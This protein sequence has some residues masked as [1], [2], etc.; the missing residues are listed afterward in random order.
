[1]NDLACVE[2]EE[3][4][5]IELIQSEITD[6]FVLSRLIRANNCPQ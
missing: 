4:V 6:K 3:R 2:V 1:M 5:S